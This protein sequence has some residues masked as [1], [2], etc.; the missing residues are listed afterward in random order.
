M[1]AAA[2]DLV[3]RHVRMLVD[4][5]G[6]KNLPDGDLLKR[7]AGTGD[8]AAFAELLRRYAQIR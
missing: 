3:L 6:T 2:L 1:T 4:G 7:F 8:E 5:E